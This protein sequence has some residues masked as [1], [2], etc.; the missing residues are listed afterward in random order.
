MMFGIGIP[1]FTPATSADGSV[2]SGVVAAVVLAVVL[3]FAVWTYMRSRPIR[4][5]A[6]ERMVEL[7]K[8]A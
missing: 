8:A 5:V 1:T 3:A 4:H 6:D 2:W 7:P